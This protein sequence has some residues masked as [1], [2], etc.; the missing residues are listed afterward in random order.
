MRDMI[1][2]EFRKNQHL[3]NADDIHN[4]RWNAVK[5]LHNYLMFS[6]G[7]TSTET[8]PSSSEETPES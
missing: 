1:R 6:S 5:A 8:I 7:Y 2:S 3:S 4:A